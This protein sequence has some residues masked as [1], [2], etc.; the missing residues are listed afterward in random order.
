MLKTKIMIAARS[1]KLI[2]DITEIKLFFLSLND[3]YVDRNLYFNLVIGDNTIRDTEI[4]DCALAFFLVGSDAELPET[5]KAALNSYNKTGRPKIFTYV[6]IQ[7]SGVRGQG[8]ED[9]SSQQG[10]G[11]GQLTIDNGQLISGESR[12]ESGA[13][14][15]HF[16]N[17]QFPIN[18]T[19]HTQNSTLFPVR[20]Y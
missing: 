6:K 7:D 10:S 1:D 2:S 20:P 4:E 17:S 15:A 12:K 11:N 14:S 18:S 19:L 3:C 5:Y 9:G 16:S 8:S 13:L